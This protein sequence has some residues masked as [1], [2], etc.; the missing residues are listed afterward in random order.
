M[1]VFTLDYHINNKVKYRN[2]IGLNSMS[3]KK[4]ILLRISSKDHGN[5]VHELINM[6]NNI[7]DEKF[8]ISIL[9][10][11]SDDSFIRDLAIDTRIISLVKGSDN[12]SKIPVLSLFQFIFRWLTLLFY[13]C[14]PSAI[15]NKVCMTPDIE[16]AFDVS[17][18]QMLVKSPFTKSKKVYWY[19]SDVTED[20]TVDHCRRVAKMM[21]C[22]HTTV[23]RS[24]YAQQFFESFL[25]VKI[26]RSIHIHPY[27]NTKEVIRK[28]LE[29][30]SGLEELFSGTEKV[31]ITVGRLIYSNRYDVLLAAHAEL[32]SEGFLHKII[33]IGEGSEYEHLKKNTRRL[34]AEDRF[35][36]LGNRD[37]PYPYINRADYYIK[38]SRHESY[39]EMLREVLVLQ[40]P[41]IITDDGGIGELLTDWGTAY[42]IQFDKREIKE[43]MKKFISDANFTEKM[44]AE[45]KKIDFQKSNLIT[46]DYVNDLFSNIL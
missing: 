39:P 10:D 17:S 19:S 28:S 33:V 11:Y 36:F 41:A 37:N 7:N 31:F 4:R 35:V 8:D 26:P 12:R 44:K 13:R 15:K 20:F 29:T 43:A 5:N 25:G 45:Q 9:V 27:I 38:P 40:K 42:L 30:P 23:F 24:L 3:V 34:K 18:A 22:C 1:G 6:I 16:V 21:C 32:I 46:C 14:F 2:I